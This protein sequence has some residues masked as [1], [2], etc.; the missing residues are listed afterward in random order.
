MSVKDI[1]KLLFKS[2][3]FI[4]LKNRVTELENEI[5]DLR[6][7]YQRIKYCECCPVGERQSLEYKHHIDNTLAR[8]ECPKSGKPYFLSPGA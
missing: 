1:L 6:K 8:Y 4:S 7:N 3:E 2:D 5:D